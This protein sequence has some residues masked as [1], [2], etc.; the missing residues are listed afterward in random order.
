MTKQFGSDWV[1]ASVSHATM[2][3]KDLVLR[4]ETVLECAGVDLSNN[5]D[6]PAI[7][8]AFLDNPDHVSDK[9]LEQVDY[10]VEA[11]FDA[12]NDVAPEGCY[13][14]ASEDDG[15]DYGF[16]QV[17][18]DEDEDAEATE[19]QEDDY[20]TTDHIHWYQYGQLVLTTADSNDPHA[21]ADNAFALVK[22]HMDG[23]KWWPNVWFISDHGNAHLVQLY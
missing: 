16:W 7:V 15:S 1:N 21:S 5:W 14:G 13:F 20:T 10:Y 17:Q 3:P 2:Q 19:P 23:A 12:L 6:R 11:L 9:G 18:E 8:A 22:A 4:F